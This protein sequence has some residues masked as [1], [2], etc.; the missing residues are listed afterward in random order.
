M[1]NGTPVNANPET[2]RLWAQLETQRREIEAMT[3]ALAARDA[4]LQQQQ[5]GLCFPEQHHH[6]IMPAP[7]LPLEELHH[8]HAEALL[9]VAAPLMVEMPVATAAPVLGEKRER[10]HGELSDDTAEVEE[11][12]ALSG[13]EAREEEVR[14]TGSEEVGRG[15]RMKRESVLMADHVQHFDHLL[16]APRQSAM[17]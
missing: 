17:V 8:F 5:Q 16:V 12:E 7:L 14:V 2:D 13:E 15:K 3:R 10:D 9:P 11:E 6:A 1:N 4:I